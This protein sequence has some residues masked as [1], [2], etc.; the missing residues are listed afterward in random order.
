MSRAPS[1]WSSAASRLPTLPQ[2]WSA[3]V[4]P[5]RSS[6][7][8]RW[9]AAAWIARSTPRAVHGDGSPPSPARPLTWRVSRRMSSMSAGVVPTSSPVTNLP[10]RRS[11]KRPCAR[12]SRSRSSGSAP[13]RRTTALPPPT[14]M[15]ARAFL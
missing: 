15:P 7:P 2:P 10:P 12:K 1:R 6:L 13:L 11:M 4:R 5:A 14:S 9:R 8:Q 3:T